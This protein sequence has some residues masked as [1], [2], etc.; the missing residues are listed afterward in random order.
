M[1]WTIAFK[2]ASA[3]FDVV[4]DPIG[5]YPSKLSACDVVID[6]LEANRRELARAIR[7]AK[8]MRRRAARCPR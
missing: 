1:S 4:K 2:L 8:Q 3:D 5:P 7:K 6:V